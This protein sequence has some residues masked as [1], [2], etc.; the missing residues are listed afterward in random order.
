MF[1]TLKVLVISIF[2]IVNLA[3]AMELPLPVG[4]IDWNDT[5]S[6]RYDSTSDYIGSLV[7]VCRFLYGAPNRAALIKF[8]PTFYKEYKEKRKETRCVDDILNHVIEKYPT[9]LAQHRNNLYRLANPH[10][11]NIE[12]AAIVNELKKRGM[13]QALVS[14]I[15]VDSYNYISQKHYPS[16]FKNFDGGFCKNLIDPKTG[17]PYSSYEKLDARFFI[18]LRKYLND[19]NLIKDGQNIIFIDDNPNYI[20][21]AQESNDG[22]PIKIESI[23]FKSGKQVWSELQARGLLSQDANL[24]DAIQDVGIRFGIN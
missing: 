7:D 22:S 18:G 23:Q 2:C 6:K 19:N 10:K 13:K 12:M 15:G 1:R 4:A 20:S 9:I 21:A 3:F 8:I 5:L 16:F 17:K 14:N 24:S 11:L